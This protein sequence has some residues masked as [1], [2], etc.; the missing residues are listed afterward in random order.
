MIMKNKANT[1]SLSEQVK[2]HKDLYYQGKPE[3]SDSEYDLLEEKLKIEDPKNPVLARVGSKP[4][5]SNKVRHDYKMLSLDKTYKIDDLLKWRNENEVV[6]TFKIDGVSCS[7]I[8]ENGK[9]VLAKT[10]GDGSIGENITNKVAYISTIPKKIKN[11]KR[12]EIRG[13]LY[14]IE[15][16][17]FKLR[18]EMEKRGLDKPSSQRNI[19][20]GLISRKENLELSKYLDFQAFELI[21]ASIDLSKEVDKFKFL[22]E[23]SFI[24]PD[25]VDHKN[26]KSIDIEIKRAKDFMSKGEYLIDGIVF[27]YNDLRLHNT[28]GETAHH[29]RYKM[30][31]K[32][33]GES[34]VT[35]IK[36]IIWSI[37][38]NGIYT[39]IADVEPVKL[40]GASISRVTLHNYGLVRQY[41]LKSGDKIEIIRS[42]EVIPKFLSV[43]ESSK[44]RIKLIEN[45][46]YC[47]TKI[48]TVDIRLICPNNKCLG[49]IKEEILNF[50]KK[51]GI[52]DLSS[53]RLDELITNNLV[54]DFSDLYKIKIEDL[55]QIDKV[56]DTLASKLVNSIQKSKDVDLA[57][58]LASLGISGGAY[59]KCEKIVQ[60]G[61]NSLEKIKTLTKDQLIEVD[62]FA[63]KSATDFLKS[64][65]SKSSI[66]KKLENVGFIFEEIEKTQT[67]LTDKKICITGSLSEKRSV[68]EKSIRDAGGIVVTSVTKKIDLLLCNDTESSSSKF[69][70]AKQLEIEIISES[71]LKKLL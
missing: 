57:T 64:L 6:S 48:K 52:N 26:K 10:R 17:F 60:S 41:N 34:K 28:L 39:P 63:E 8:Y 61:F 25:Y 59:N 35:Q 29:P 55:V 7:L 43:V 1:T 9:L 58:F 22:S 19:V 15:E 24:I 62:S 70:K 14:C 11:T 27:T 69:T 54:K 71:D 67:A 20:A 46:Y 31:F 2:Y 47:E 30:A 32:F 12:I 53:K 42:G 56:K 38:R 37:S 65:K 16:K 66:I 33:Q 21:S 40:G 44:N 68:I 13:E 49:I 50:I 45:C 23:L 3:I 36:D 18:E 5:G 51:V 4:I